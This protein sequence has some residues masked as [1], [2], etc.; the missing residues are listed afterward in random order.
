M[1]I[2][3]DK[4]WKTVLV[5]LSAYLNFIAFVL[6]GGY[7]HIKNDDEEVQ[8]ATKQ[9]FIVT[10]GYTAITALLSIFNYVGNFMDNY[11]SSAAYEFCSTLNTLVSISKVI[12]FAVFIIFAFV[13]KDEPGASEDKK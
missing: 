11:Y 6:V 3:W 1:K 13:N 2:T 12:V 7:F 4:K 8:L 5:W 9:A 10:L